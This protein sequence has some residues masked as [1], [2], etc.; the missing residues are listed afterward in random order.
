MSLI[1][2]RAYL[3]NHSLEDIIDRLYKEI[4]GNSISCKR[5]RDLFFIERMLFL[6]RKLE[7]KC[8]QKLE[9]PEKQKAAEVLFYL[10]YHL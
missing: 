4:G 7:H 8:R 6:L 3:S 5:W 10:I 9:V 1:V 2:Q